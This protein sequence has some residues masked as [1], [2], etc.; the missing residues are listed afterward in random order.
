[1]LSKNPG[2]SCLSIG[3][4]G[5]GFPF[6]GMSGQG[7]LFLGCRD[8]VSFSKDAVTGFTSF[9]VLAGISFFKLVSLKGWDFAL[10][11]ENNFLKTYY[12]MRHV[13]N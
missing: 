13:T 12:K 2:Q 11:R 8:R 1:M 9:K 7:F 5:Q 3:M 10:D 4:S 6:L